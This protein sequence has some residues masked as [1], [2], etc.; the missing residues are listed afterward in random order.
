MIPIV[1]SF[2]RTLSFIASY[3]D[4]NP[5][6][7]KSTTKSNLPSSA[8]DSSAGNVSFLED[9][10]NVLRDAFIKCL[11][12]SPGTPRST[13]PLPSD[14]RVGIYLTANATLKLL[15]R[16][17][18]IRNAQQIVLSIDAQ[19]PPLSFY[20]AAQRV[21][22]LYYIGRYHFANNHFLRAATVLQ[23]AYSQCHRDALSHRRSILV[24]LVASNLILGKLPSQSL[25]SRS[26]AAPLAQHFLPLT[27]IIRSGDIGAFQQ[28]LSLSSA[29]STWFLRRRILLQIRNRCE[30]LVWR[31]LIRK[32]FILAG[33]HGEDKKM[34]FL[35]LHV[36]RHAARF[37]LARAASMS[38]LNSSGARSGSADPANYID[39]EFLNIKSAER[40]TGFDL[41][42]GSYVSPNQISEV[43]HFPPQSALPDDQQSPTIAEIQSVVLSLIQQGFLRGFLNRQVDRPG[44]S[45]FAIRSKKGVPAVVGGFPDI[46][47]VV[48]SN[49]TEEGAVPGWVREEN[50]GGGMRAGAAGNLAGRRIQISGR[51]IAA[52]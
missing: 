42:T 13:R 14:K 43:D 21:T 4:R 29:S 35:R 23:S 27:K 6:I 34:P 18:K 9:T 15:F 52:S 30:V 48:I 51:P 47:S 39:P 22:Y 3:L 2:S 16:A 50:L 7:L 11:A 25:L 45:R 12:G 1:L 32:C 40:D 44:M 46:Y 28:Y 37:S 8:A 5:H 33:F 24:Y 19:S 20:P 41:Q 17:R 10:A 49:G 26:D 31:S 36:V 38:N